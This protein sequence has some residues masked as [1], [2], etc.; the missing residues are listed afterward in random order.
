MTKKQK[1]KRVIMYSGLTDDKNNAILCTNKTAN[2]KFDYIN[3]ITFTLIV[4]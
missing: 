2:F 3:Y 1:Q 4:L